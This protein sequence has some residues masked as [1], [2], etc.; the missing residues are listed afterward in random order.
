[1][2]SHR[3]QGVRVDDVT[4]EETLAAIQA[5]IESGTAHQLATV[6]PE[7]IMRARHD[8][9]FRRVINHSDLALPDGAGLLIMGTLT[10]RKI[11][12]RVTGADLTLMLAERA[13]KEG[14][15][16]FL[17]GAAEGV[18]QAAAD[19]LTAMYPGLNIVGT[20][21][22][23]PGA[24]DR[25]IVSQIKHANPDILL[26]AYGAP[27]QDL[28]ISRHQ[29]ELGIPL[30]MGVGGTFDF[31][32]GTVKRAPGWMRKVGLEW[33]WRLMQEPWRWRRMLALPKFAILSL[34][35]G[36]GLLRS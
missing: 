26:V 3:F 1:M 23:S 13:T 19:K 22:G 15:K 30:A 24:D 34:L 20:S 6:N 11:R 16:I 10:G 31:I 29:G 7:F 36:I 5:F 18:A 32:A 28:W 21:A 35:E 25:T 9:A 33:L 12:Q 27:K 2:K 8:H 4:A 14:W 17:L